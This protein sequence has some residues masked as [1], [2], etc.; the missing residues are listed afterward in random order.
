VQFTNASSASATGWS[1]NFGD[2]V[3]VSG[4]EHPA[5]AYSDA[6]TYTVTLIA[7]NNC[8]ASPPVTQTVTINQAPVSD[9]SLTAPA[10]VGAPVSFTD[11]S[12][13]GPTSWQWDF[14][15][16][17]TSTAQNPAH[18]YAALGSYAVSLTTANG[19]GTG[20]TAAETVSVSAVLSPSFAATTPVCLGETTYFTDT[21]AGDVQTWLWDFGDGVTSTKQHP[22]HV[23]AAASV[24]TV[25][26][27]TANACGAFSASADVEVTGATPTAAFTPAKTT[28]C[29]NEAVCFTNASSG[30]TYYFWDFG[31][32]ADFSND[33]NPCFAWSSAGTYTVTLTASNACG[34]GASASVQMTVQPVPVAN[35]DY[36]TTGNN[37][38]KN[39]DVDFTDL[40][41]N[42]PI[43]WQWDFGDGTTSTLQ[44]PVHQYALDGVYVVTLVATNACGASAPFSRPIT[45]HATCQTNCS[46]NSRQINCQSGAPV[47]ATGDTLVDFDN[48]DTSFYGCRP[49]IFY[50][51]SN[52]TFRL[53]AEDGST[54]RIT[55]TETGADPSAYELDLMLSHFCN[56]P[57]CIAWG[58]TE[59]VFD[60]ALYPPKTGTYFLIVDGRDGTG[61]PFELQ[62]E[63][64]PPG[65]QTLCTPPTFGGIEGAQDD[66]PCAYGGILVSWSAALDWGTAPDGSACASGTYDV[67]RAPTSDL[68]DIVVVGSSIS[69]LSYV[70]IMV[71]PNTEYTYWVHAVNAC[72]GM[73]AITA[74]NLPAMDFS[75]EE[76][77]F[78]GIVSASD[79]DICV[80]TGVVIAWTP[81]AHF[82]GGDGTYRILRTTRLDCGAPEIVATV[83]S[84]ETSYTDNGAADN[85]L[86]YYRV[87]AVSECGLADDG[88]AG[89][90]PAADYVATPPSFLGIDEALDADLCVAPSGIEVSWREI[91]ISSDWGG[92]CTSGTY[93]VYRDGVPI[94]SGLAAS[95]YADTM[96][97]A[98]VSYT[99]RVE[100]VNDCCGVADGN[101]RTASAEDESA[102]PPVFA[103]INTAQDVDPCQDTG[104]LLTW[105]DASDWGS[106]ATGTY[107]VYRDGVPI[108]SGLAGSSYTDTTGTNE[109]LYSYRVEAVNDA[110]GLTDGN[111]VERQAADSLLGTE[112]TASFATGSVACAGQTVLFVDTSTGSPT[113]WQWDFGDGN[114]TTA[115]HPTHVYAASG[116]Y[117]VTLVASNSCGASAPYSQTVEVKTVPT[118]A[119]SAP[120]SE[121]AGNAVA[122]ADT[123]TQSPTAWGWDFGDGTTSTLQNPTHAYALPG[124][125][126]VSLQV[127]NECGTS[128]VFDRTI[129]IVES[130]VANFTHNA[131]Q[132]AGNAVSFI[133]TSTGLP[134]V[135][136]WD[137][138][139][140]TTSTLQNPTHAYAAPGTYT[141]TLIASIFCGAS[142]P[143]SYTVEILAPSDAGFTHDAPQCT[144]SAVSFTDVSTGSPT[145]WQWDFGDGM[146]STLQNPTHVYNAGGTY[147]VTL[148]V[149]GDCG[150][151]PS[152]SDAVAIDPAP[153]VDFTSDSP[154]C[155]GQAI[156]FTDTST[157]NPTA[158]Q[159]DF[160]GGATST[161][162]NPTYAYAASGDYTVTLTVSNACGTGSP[163]SRIVHALPVPVANFTHNAPQCVGSAVSFVDA[164]SSTPT[165]WSWDFGDGTT[166]TLQNPTHTYAATGSYVVTL[167]ASNVCGASAPFS[168]TVVISPPPVADFV[169]DAPQCSGSAVQF[170]DLS[171]GDVTSWFW[172]FGD[173]KGTSS[174]Q[175]PAYTYILPGTYSVVLTVTNACGLVSSATQSV[176]VYSNTFSFAGLQSVDYGG[177]CILTLTWDPA[178]PGCSGGVQNDVVYNVYRDTQSDFIPDPATNMIA[179]CL[180]GTTYDD[181]A[182]VAGTTYH[183]IVRAE[184]S[185]SGNGGPCADGLEDG[186]FIRKNAT[187]QN[188][189]D[190]IF[191]D[192]MESGVN[193]WSATGQWN[194][195]SDVVCTNP[196]PSYTSPTTAWYFGN[197]ANCNYD[198]GAFSGDLISPPVSGITLVSVLNAKL[199]RQADACQA[200][201]NQIS[202]DVSLAGV[203]SWT[204]LYYRDS[205][206][207]PLSEWED[208][209]D[210][211]LASWAGQTIEIRIRFANGADWSSDLGWC[212]FNQSLTLQIG[213]LVDDVHV[214]NKTTAPFAQ[215]SAADPGCSGV[216]IQFTD[217]TIGAPT[218]WQWDFGDGNTST[219]Q[220]PT[221]AYAAEGTYTVTLTASNSC[222]ASA[223]NSDTVSVVSSTP[224]SSFTAPASACTG[225]AASFTDAS[226]DAGAWAW[227]FG[228]G[229]TSTLQNPTHTYAATGTYTVTLVA[230]NGCGSGAPYDQTVTVDESP[231][232]AFDAPQTGCANVPVSFT[233]TS[234]GSPTSWTWS[235]GDGNTSTLQNP[236]HAYAAAGTYPVGLTVTNACGASF[237]S[238]GISIAPLADS[239]GVGLRRREHLLG[240]ESHPLL[241]GGGHLHG[242]AGRLESMR[243]ERAARFA[244]DQRNGRAAGVVYPQRAPVRRHRR[245]VHGRVDG[246]ADGVA[247][248]LR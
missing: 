229:N 103:G 247:V 48:Y 155:V 116:T 32:G 199:W 223:P 209:G 177:P 68:T 179:S 44:D 10:C 188:S 192:D 64:I 204:T 140:G 154:Q 219:V 245:P 159:W 53:N 121:C 94:A 174:L 29:V 144:G 130:P 87:E 211:S 137:F 105:D 237:F 92:A 9:F 61:G 244:G 127:Q 115:Q 17:N 11:L 183:Y 132:C 82:G 28:V 126:T 167:V 67:Y 194:Q 15:D 186:N 145:A 19:C 37:F 197:A 139:D 75:N 89:C 117:T 136:Q 218:A 20:T 39:K 151:S 175:G 4:E 157:G 239:V 107:N 152:F 8:G 224:V 47:T 96:T 2:G 104:V 71:V 106:G 45:I 84:S 46:A 141:V 30:A 169:S 93:N 110:C 27:T 35:F 63:C 189:V 164:S 91:V 73:A 220:N 222:A 56:P 171:T 148:V 156:S 180:T 88:G 158:W 86:Y 233:D 57:E 59:L 142:A 221:H 80:D 243:R 248:G 129:D 102:Q 50:S 134:T 191:L 113:A 153:T 162:Q 79:P 172:D 85:V 33:V 108:A 6:G 210:L 238:K 232:A 235:F 72:C 207:V 70:D 208:T 7:F 52:A 206:D 21:T 230:S 77:S 201:R 97:A 12:T 193:G 195:V 3:G 99:Y 200:N 60:T 23:Y 202:I 166:S 100:A 147:T 65:Q 212:G 161:L 42:S 112:P 90:L 69:G 118:A 217:E 22:D 111:A 25:T 228:D 128:A 58:D 150:A 125:Y 49:D 1:W 5:Y 95:P 190:T 173:G 143:A 83:P 246:S 14:G 203:G 160:G 240:A 138:G 38:C 109:V 242:H 213:I 66:D 226:T 165:A 122:F 214:S 41:T 131:P 40:S 101:T 176:V 31:T 24:Y 184:T 76:P 36:S 231:T 51:G 123:S 196:S 170:T 114:T 234:T 227:D 168:A 34:A 74:N 216:P 163:F 124:T 198:A 13:D 62:V 26:L 119:F 225:A 181:S 185:L 241:R 215:F 182:T 149:V 146:A 187:A 120:L 205:D 133:D 43:A 78:G 81:A 18:T 98:G 55:L 178:N 135:W 236:T 54:Y 16:G